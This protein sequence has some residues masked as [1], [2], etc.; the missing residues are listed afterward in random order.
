M[1]LAA[2]IFGALALQFR[3]ADGLTPGSAELSYVREIATVTLA[4]SLRAVLHPDRL[5]MV[6]RGELHRRPGRLAAGAMAMVCAAYVLITFWQFRNACATAPGVGCYNVRDPLDLA[7][8]GRDRG[9]CV[10][11][12]S[13]NA[14]PPDLMGDAGSLLRWAASSPGSSVLSRTRCSPW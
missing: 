11:F 3:N 2:V 13:W 9:T 1:L 8:M 7:L 14:A 10:G 5:C 12:L 6:E 4:P